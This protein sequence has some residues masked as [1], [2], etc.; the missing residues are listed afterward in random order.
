MGKHC[1]KA[2]TGLGEAEETD[3]CAEDGR[4]LE[5]PGLPTVEE[6]EGLFWVSLG[7]VL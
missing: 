7:C 4:A 6:V 2:A 3:H 5:L 1:L